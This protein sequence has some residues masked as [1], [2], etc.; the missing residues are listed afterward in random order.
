[1]S[2]YKFS[3]NKFLQLLEASDINMLKKAKEFEKLDHKVSSSWLKNSMS[4]EELQEASLRYLSLA[5]KIQKVQKEAN[6][7][8]KS[9]ASNLTGLQINILKLIADWSN[10]LK[11]SYKYYSDYLAYGKVDDE[12][13]SA[14]LK[15]EAITKKAEF[16]ELLISL[17]GRM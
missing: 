14:G 1:M 6:L 10:I 15:E 3:N 16:K 4:E 13:I 2:N 5:S 17:K 11:Q 12:H 9:R 8:L 7:L